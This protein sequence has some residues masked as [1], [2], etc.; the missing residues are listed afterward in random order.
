M[1]QKT[2]RITDEQQNF[3]EDRAINFS[4]FVRNALDERMDEVG[5]SGS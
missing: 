5:Y 1:K 4:E 3:I 2:T